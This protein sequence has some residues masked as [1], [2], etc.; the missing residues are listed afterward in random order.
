[1]LQLKNNTP[2]EASIALFPNEKGIDSIYAMIKA[3]FSIGSTLS[4]APEQTPVATAD[5]YWGKPLTSSL[6]Q[7]SEFHL[8]KP[9]TDIIMVGAACAPDQTPVRTLDVTLSVGKYQK[10]VKVFGDRRWI[11]G[12]S[13]LKISKPAPFETMPL[14]YERAFG[15]TFEH[16]Y[17]K[18]Q[19]LSEPRNPVGVG[20][21]GKRTTSQMKDTALPNVE[22]PAKLIKKPGD[23]P[24]P[25]GFSFIAPSWEPRVQ[26]AGTYDDKWTTHRAPYLPDDFDPRFFNSA[27]N[28][29]ISDTYLEGGEPVFISNMSGDGPLTFKLPIVTFNLGISIEGKE[30]NPQI[31]LETI[32]LSP[33]EKELTMLW[34]AA[35]ACDKKALKVEEIRI[36]QNDI[37]LN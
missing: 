33:N 8:I 9:T 7:A 11:S 18:N 15:G 31:N 29:L 21:L 17:K 28:E 26:Y 20:F 37:M 35:V 23:H 5:V 30:Q 34:R 22:D 27:S 36:E 12:S 10:T 3:T 13:G 4:V 16:K 1:M 2:F 24:P 14:I 32:C 6:K 25:A 19:V